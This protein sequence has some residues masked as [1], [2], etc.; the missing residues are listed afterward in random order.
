MSGEASMKNRRFSV[1]IMVVIISATC[2]ITGYSAP[3][4]STS[5]PSDDVTLSPADEKELEKMLENWESSNDPQSL[6]PWDISEDQLSQMD[7]GVTQLEPELFYDAQRGLW[8]YKIPNQSKY[9]ISIPNGMDTNRPVLIR[10]MDNAYVKLEQNGQAIEIP[11]DGYLSEVG[12]YHLQLT[13]YNSNPM[14]TDYNIYQVDHYFRIIP[15]SVNNLSLLM[16]PKGFCIKEISADGRPVL[17]DDRYWSFLEKDGKYKVQYEWEENPVYTCDMSFVRDT[18]APFVQ[19]NP[20]LTGKMMKFPVLYEV[21]ESGTSMKINRDGLL[22]DRADGQIN[23][24][25][26]YQIMVSDRAGNT[27]EYSLQTKSQLLVFG[28]K[29]LIIT[30]I[31]FICMVVALIR[32]R[33][34]MTVL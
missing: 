12:T 7:Q 13:V 5:D 9:Y 28:K 8:G 26:N 11:L 18:V 24:A 20:G 29:E 1:I 4:T 15:H 14:S 31:L 2:V 19:F 25:G 30:I 34:R 27:R 21:E 16:A 22:L 3:R 32:Y 10:P 17:P 6:R 23:T 33:R